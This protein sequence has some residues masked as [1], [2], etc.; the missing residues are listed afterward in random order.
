[1]VAKVNAEPNFTIEK[2]QRV[3]GES[4]YTSAE[5]SAQGGQ[6][7]EYKIVVKNTGNV[8]IKFGALKDSGCEGITPPAPPNSPPAAK[9]PSL[10]PTA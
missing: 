10:A 1:M 4:S 9:S 7:M 3:N 8:T 2:Q 6:T 5:R